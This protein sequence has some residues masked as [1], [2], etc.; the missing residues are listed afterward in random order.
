MTG[1]E[2][3]RTE[4]R[5]AERCGEERRGEERRG[6][7]KMQDGWLTTVS[8]LHR[9]TGHEECPDYTAGKGGGHARD[10]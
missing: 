3:S 1:A 4:R 2:R 9:V 6:E 5:G 8:E 7:E 10:G